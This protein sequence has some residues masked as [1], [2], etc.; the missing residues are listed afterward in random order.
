MWRGSHQECSRSNQ[1]GSAQVPG[2]PCFFCRR[3]G[4]IQQGES[5]TPQGFRSATCHLHYTF[6]AGQN[7]VDAFKQQGESSMPQGFK[8]ATRCLYCTFAVPCATYTYWWPALAL[9]FLCKSCS[10]PPVHTTHCAKAMSFV[11]L[12]VHKP[13]AKAASVDAGQ[14]KG[15]PACIPNRC[16]SS[17]RDPPNV[18]C[19]PDFPH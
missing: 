11:Y 7:K 6:A 13:A 9:S 8:I 12:C 18:C 2:H 3:Q 5:S 4:C 16:C 15:A 14:A 19:A 17:I 1:V 10:T